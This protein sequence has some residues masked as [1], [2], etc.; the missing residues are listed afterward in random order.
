ML[1]LETDYL[2]FILLLFKFIYYI[3]TSCLGSLIALVI[4]HLV[5]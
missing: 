4:Y 5:S 3:L 2:E 1:N